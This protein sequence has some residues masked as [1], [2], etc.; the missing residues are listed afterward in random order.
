MLK[1]LFCFLFIFTFSYAMAQ[2]ILTADDFL[3]Q[4][5][6]KYGTIE[7]YEAGISILQGETE[8]SGTIYYKN[9]HLIRI[10]FTQPPGQI[11]TVDGENLLIYLPQHAVTLEQRLPRKSS[12][13]IASMARQQGLIYL[14]NNYT[15]SYAVGPDKIPL[16]E[17]HEDELVVKLRFIWRHSAEGYKELEISFDS[18]HLIR[19]IKGI[20]VQ[21]V[22]VQFDFEN[23]RLN[24]NLPDQLFNEESPATAYVYKNF[25]FEEDN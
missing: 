6:A 9:P 18:N 1:K 11:L 7:D 23:I 12:A 22:L 3:E 4:A 16:D 14:I 19:R 8:M 10:D 15:V 13:A 21:N 17:N 25:L 2:E 5:S 20:T 24:Q